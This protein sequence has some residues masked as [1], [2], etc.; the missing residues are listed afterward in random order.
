MSK[1]SPTDLAIT[2]R[3]VP[4]RL[5]EAL[6]DDQPA[7]DTALHGQL[8]RAASLLGT[9]PDATSI[10]DAINRIPADKWDQAVLDGLR[11]IALEVG[12]QLRQLAAQHHAADD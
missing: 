2:F 11:G 6:G 9:A 12:A 5:R 3:S 10:A 8:A 4:R 1:T 7:A